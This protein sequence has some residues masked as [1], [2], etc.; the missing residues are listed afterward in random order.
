M[1]T[2]TVDLETWCRLVYRIKELEAANSKLHDELH[3]I[4]Y[5]IMGGEDAPGSACAVTLD[6][7][8][9]EIERKLE[10]ALRRVNH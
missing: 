2:I 8:K 3:A 7:I 6:D 5:E 9:K 1:N 10:A 4:K